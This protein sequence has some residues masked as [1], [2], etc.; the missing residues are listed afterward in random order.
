MNFPVAELS[1]VGSDYRRLCLVLNVF[2]D[3][4][5][6][7]K[8]SVL[9]TSLLL[10][11][12]FLPVGKNAEVM[13]ADGPDLSW[14]FLYDKAHIFPTYNLLVDGFSALLPGVL[15]LI[16]NSR[17]LPVWLDPK[18]SHINGK[19]NRSLLTGCCFMACEFQIPDFLRKQSIK[20][21]QV[22]PHPLLRRL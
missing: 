4:K 6:K 5:R 7:G 8:G 11:F 14:G 21:A 13:S 17:V 19:E 1:P 10:G 18:E 2:E 22:S 20:R 9:E 15:L 3:T 16:P 12:A